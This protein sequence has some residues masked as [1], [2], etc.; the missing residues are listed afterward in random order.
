M[1]SCYFID[2][3]G[4]LKL[5]KLSDEDTRYTILEC[6]IKGKINYS[7]MIYPMILASTPDKYLDKIKIALKA[8]KHK[9]KYIVIDSNDDGEC[10]ILIYKKDKDLSRV[11]LY[12]YLLQH[13]KKY[14]D[15]NFNPI[16]YI[17]HDLRGYGKDYN[18]RFF[19]Q[20]YINRI[21]PKEYPKEIKKI[22]DNPKLSINQK[23]MAKYNFIKN[24]DNFKSFNKHYADLEKLVEKILKDIKNSN[25]L[26]KY[27]KSIKPHNFEFTLKHSIG[28]NPMY[29]LVEDDVHKYAKKIDVKL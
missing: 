22:M 23:Y 7:E 4:A 1:E 17:N 29:K 6:L 19:I 18:H 16:D 27:T 10:L 28:D 13:F 3:Y 12:S 8:V 2:K 9:M 15:H 5:K 20:K 24:K 25:N 26:I 11:I 21:L 14:E